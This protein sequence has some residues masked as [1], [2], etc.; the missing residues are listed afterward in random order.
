MTR[1][2]TLIL[3]VLIAALLA[4][5]GPAA[6]STL[7]RTLRPEG[8]GLGIRLVV[9][10]GERHQVLVAERARPTAGRRTRRRSLAYFAHL[11]DLHLTDE[12][13][14]ARHESLRGVR[15]AFGSLWRPQ[16]VFGL[17]VADRMVRAVNR[18]R[19]SG[20]RSAGGPA[21]LRFALATGDVA[22]NAQVNE[23]RWAVRVL[24]GGRV[25][26]S[27]GRRI[28]RRN[29]CAAPAPVVRRLNRSVSRRRYAGVRGLYRKLNAGHPG[30]LHRAQRP[31]VAEGL[32][33]P[34]Y[35]ARGNHDALP[36]GHFGPAVVRP[37][38]APIGCRKVLSARV[39]AA[40]PLRTQP[41][42][43]LRARLPSASFVPPDPRRR[44]LRSA[45]EFRRLHGRADRRHGFALTA[46]SERRR[47]RGSALYYA[48]SPRPGLRFISLDTVAD[49]GDS[50]GNVD[51][52]QYRWLQ[53]ELARARR[54]GRV[55]VIYAHHSLE[56]M[57]NRRHDEWAGRFDR[58]PRDSR[59]L[60]LGR[61]GRASIR[62]LLL[63]HP[64]VVLYVT[65]HNHYERIRPHF[66][67][68]GRGFW[69]VTTGSPSGPP[70]QARLIELMDNRDGTLSIFT[71]M[72]DQAAPPR[73]PAP[74]P[75]S[76]IGPD[77]LASLSRI[78]AW[79]RRP[80]G[81]AGRPRLTAARRLRNVELV[82]RDPR[83]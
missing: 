14:P 4:A 35:A 9:G 5:A 65:G 81:P 7:E 2:P 25:D 54:R 73:P 71:T 22:D 45:A 79:T 11:T 36:Q 28:S 50:G 13:S 32:T 19:V 63:R 62:S 76:A 64:N 47:S 8:R 16:E 24:E 23:V 46:R 38:S 33:V 61:T 83:R 72:V 80:L 15:R 21:R 10:P 42:A 78:I 69:Q 77:G 66:R 18:E 26:P 20:L 60:H 74:G 55:V 1:R 17:H 6:A 29:P 52:P 82:L 51:D 12:A 40:G 56:R 68:G 39:P 37:R 75:A 43:L 44:F 30:I 31:F 34:W 58:D 57:T 59:P 3:P 49:A 48:W 53:R 41:W 70:Q 67:P 27:S